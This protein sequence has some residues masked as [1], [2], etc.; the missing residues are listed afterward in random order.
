MLKVVTLGCTRNLSV[1]PIFPFS[2]LNLVWLMP[3]ACLM[4]IYF[5]WFHN[6]NLTLVLGLFSS[7]ARRTFFQDIFYWTLR[8]ICYTHIHNHSLSGSDGNDKIAVN[9]I[10]RRGNVWCRKRLSGKVTIVINWLC[11]VF[12]QI[13][14]LFF[15]LQFFILSFLPPSLC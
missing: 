7:N 15:W 6:C 12:G 14:T 10:S 1:L 4:L 8:G 2:Y 11:S 3:F 5:H 9:A 13:E